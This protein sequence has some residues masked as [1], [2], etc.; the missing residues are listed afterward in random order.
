MQLHRLKKYTH[1]CCF[2]YRLRKMLQ[3][4]ARTHTLLYISIEFEIIFFRRGHLYVIK[5]M[6]LS[7]YAF[8]YECRKRKRPWRIIGRMQQNTGN[9]WNPVT[10]L[11]YILKNVVYKSH[12]DKLLYVSFYIKILSLS[13]TLFF[14]SLFQVNSHWR[15]VQDRLEDDERCSRLEK[16][17]R[18]LIFEV[19]CLIYA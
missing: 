9:F 8:I 4:C 14:S 3:R 17:D 10:L 6:L 12:R 11:R 18:L 7:F 5:H 13:F 2:A 1:N 19:F 15:K 16:L